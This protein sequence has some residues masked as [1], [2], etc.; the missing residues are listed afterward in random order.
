[1]TISD[2][3]FQALLDQR[4][5]RGIEMINDL[6]RLAFEA[7]NRTGTASDSVFEHHLR[8][9]FSQFAQAQCLALDERPREGID[10]FTLVRKL[11]RLVSDLEKHAVRTPLLHPEDNLGRGI[12]SGYLGAVR[13]VKAFA[14]K[15]W[16]GKN[17]NLGI[18]D[19]ELSTLRANWKDH[20]PLVLRL[21][22]ALQ[23][24]RW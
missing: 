22:L 12:R 4:D 8:E 2:E 19:E 17:R 15:V 9:R 5:P 3:Q 11:D 23:S 7:R 24:E 6:V 1:M 10:K 20:S 21:V 14:D 13:E 18:S 16:G